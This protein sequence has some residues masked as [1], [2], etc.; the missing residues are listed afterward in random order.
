MTGGARGFCNPAG[1]VTRPAFGQAFGYGRG[2][3][4]GRGYGAGYGA[5]YGRGRGY[6][7]GYGVMGQYP[8]WNAPYSPAYGSPYPA[9]ASQEMNMLRDEAES[10]K[11]GLDEINRRIAE[12]EK[13]SSE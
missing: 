11:R 10:M 12:L 6:G 3:G 7:R 2:F 5:G 13:A 1:A 4:R 9:D 8:P